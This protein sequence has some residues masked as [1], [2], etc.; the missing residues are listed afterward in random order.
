MNVDA[1]ID[2]RLRT[3]TQAHLFLSPLTEHNRQQMDKI[4]TQLASSSEVVFAPTL[5]INHRPMVM[6]KL[7][8]GVL[9]VN[10]DTLCVQARSQLDYIELSKHYHT[11]L[12]YEMVQMGSRNE[13]VA[14]RFLALVD[15]FY[16][17][18]V[19]L[20]INADVEMSEIYQG[21]FLRFEY[22]RC[23]SRLQEMQSEEYLSQPHL[24]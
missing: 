7:A 16:E 23:L 1:G 11:V 20:I 3:L 9:A 10:F 13:D 2:Y 5:T 4:F 24:A 15:E 6:R 17:R 12:L 14:R 8:N 19:K 22:Q 18:K 21:Q